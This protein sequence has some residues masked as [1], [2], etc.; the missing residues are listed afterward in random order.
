MPS[1]RTLNLVTLECL[2]CSTTFTAQAWAH[3]KFCSKACYHA[4]HTRPAEE[5]FWE[6]VDTSGDCWVWTGAKHV[7][8]YGKFSLRTGE[9][10]YDAH[11]ASWILANG[12]VPEGMSVLHRCDNP[13]C[14]RPDHLELGTHRQ[15]MSDMSLRNRTGMRKLTE[16]SVIQIRELARQGMTH[17]AIADQF[18]VTDGLI[19]H[20]VHRKVW[21][22]V[23]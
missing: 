22:H 12:P 23:A 11:R 13:A 1:K 20:V 9:S 14:V 2:Q 3:R 10:P 15:N 21:R 5:R 7:F 18:G 17:Q 16:E 19:W 4:S 6:K 8:G